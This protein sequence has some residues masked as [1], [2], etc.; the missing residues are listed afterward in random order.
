MCSVVTK[1]GTKH[2]SVSRGLHFSRM[3]CVAIVPP[4]TPSRS[5][6]KPEL[7]PV[8]HFLVM[9]W[10]TKNERSNER[11]P[12]RR[13]PLFGRHDAPHFAPEIATWGQ[14]CYLLRCM[15]AA[16]CGW[17]PWLHQCTGHMYVPFPLAGTASRG[18][19]IV[20]LIDNR[21]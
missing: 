4:L 3:H 12:L 14:R 15:A 2:I 16:S 10:L 13:K 18:Y 9:I 1:T 7:R 21:A 6:P 19:L 11:F 5:S 8:R 20:L 17:Y